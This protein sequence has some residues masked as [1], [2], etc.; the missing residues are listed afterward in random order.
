VVVDRDGTLRGL[1]SMREVVEV[2]LTECR[3]L[4]NRLNDQ[5]YQSALENE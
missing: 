5:Y 4:V 1:V 3:D 2:D